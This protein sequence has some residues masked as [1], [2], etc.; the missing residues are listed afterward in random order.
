MVVGVDYN[1]KSIEPKNR[2]HEIY[3]IIILN[4]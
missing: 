1:P 2:R 3:I 4:G